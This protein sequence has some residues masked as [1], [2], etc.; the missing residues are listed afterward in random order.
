MDYGYTTATTTVIEATF[1]LRDGAYVFVGK[2]RYPPRSV[3]D[4]PDDE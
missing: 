3:T 2:N 4:W 1:E